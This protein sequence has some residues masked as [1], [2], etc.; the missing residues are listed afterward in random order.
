MDREK[1]SMEKEQDL[2]DT[3]MQQ[4][5]RHDEMISSYFQLFEDPSKFLTVM[6]DLSAKIKIPNQ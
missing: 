3:F 4:E 5:A 6:D 1:Q 2:L